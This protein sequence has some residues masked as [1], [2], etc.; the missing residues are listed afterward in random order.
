VV[1][2]FTIGQDNKQSMVLICC[3][4]HVVPPT[5]IH[6]ANLYFP[7]LFLLES[8]IHS[9]PKNLAP[10]YYL[11]LVYTIPFIMH[12]FLIVATLVTLAVAEAVQWLAVYSPTYG[13][14][15]LDRRQDSCIRM[16]L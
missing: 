7:P 5:D 4:Y 1:P 10:R 11:T 16:G 9:H 3:V 15:Q 14:A 12:L 13:E 2:C 6:H 8:F